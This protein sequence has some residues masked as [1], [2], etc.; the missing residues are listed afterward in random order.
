MLGGGLAIG[1]S[2]WGASVDN[3]L[4]IDVVTT[5]LND[6]ADWDIVRIN[7]T[8]EP[9]LY[10]GMLVSCFTYPRS[11]SCLFF[12]LLG[13]TQVHSSLATDSDLQAVICLLAL[14]TVPALLSGPCLSGVQPEGCDPL[15]H[16][17]ALCW[18]TA[19]FEMQGGG[20]LLATAVGFEVQLHLLP[21]D[22]LVPTLTAVWPLPKGV[23]AFE[24]YYQWYASSP[25]AIQ[26][27]YALVT[28][29]AGAAAT[30]TATN[31]DPD[32]T[33]ESLEAMQVATCLVLVPC[34]L[35]TLFW[36]PT[37]S[38]PHISFE[39]HCEMQIDEYLTILGNPQPQPV[40]SKSLTRIPS[41]S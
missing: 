5:W 32:N 10:W 7:A 20:P 18:L 15:T 6:S 39:G 26:S 8:S 2:L 40:V 1:Q 14:L 17:V 13:A 37:S 22:S 23:E 27:S 28:T 11:D 30:A 12:Q 16:S 31:W 38:T 25:K 3:V 19:W 4:G 41:S 34:A 36:T 35:W 24:W 29:P 33:T 9:D 21:A